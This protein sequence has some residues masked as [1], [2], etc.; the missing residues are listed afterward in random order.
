MCRN[1]QFTERGIK[2][3][4][5]FGAEQWRVEP[6]F[7]VRVD[8]A[9]GDA[10]VLLEPA[11]VVAKAW[12]HIERITARSPVRPRRALVTG[13]GPIGLLAALLGVQ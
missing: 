4:H 6:E 12:D 5:G 3:L 10:A 9:L 2:E 11:S 1:G 8:P 13:A 7:V